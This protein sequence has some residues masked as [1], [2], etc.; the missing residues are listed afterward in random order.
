MCLVR[1]SLVLGLGLLSLVVWVYD[2]WLGLVL[3]FWIVVAWALSLLWFG[4]DP[5]L[6]VCCLSYGAG[7]DAMC[8]VWLGLGNL[9]VLGWVLVVWRVLIVCVGGII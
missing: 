1:C 4:W 3:G 8:C 2:V 5:H 6:S 9:V 7:F